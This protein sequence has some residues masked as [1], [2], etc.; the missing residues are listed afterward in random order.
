M[1]L[2]PLLICT[3]PDR[4]HARTHHHAFRHDAQPVK[5]LLVSLARAAS[6]RAP[7]SPGP[8]AASAP[9]GLWLEHLPPAPGVAV[10]APPPD[11]ADSGRPALLAQRHR[12]SDRRAP[13]SPE[14]RA[15]NNSCER[16]RRTRGEEQRKVLERTSGRCSGSGARDGDRNAQRHER[17]IPGWSLGAVAARPRKATR[18]S[19]ARWNGLAISRGLERKMKT[20]LG[21]FT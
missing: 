14:P 11:V 4:T 18:A 9:S 3:R 5:T 16:V 2:P 6:A 17:K 1:S 15:T 21:F 19:A 8:P 20:E 10:S 12:I 13:E 7:S